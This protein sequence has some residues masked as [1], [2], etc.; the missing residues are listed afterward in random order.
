MDT[1]FFDGELIV[2]FD[3]F[4]LKKGIDL[5]YLDKNIMLILNVIMDILIGAAFIINV[6]FKQYFK[7]Y[8]YVILPIIFLVSVLNIFSSIKNKDSK[9]YRLFYSIFWILIIL[10]LLLHI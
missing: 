1:S 10:I 4:V 6:C 2:F 7:V 5:S 9:S 3:I 8:A